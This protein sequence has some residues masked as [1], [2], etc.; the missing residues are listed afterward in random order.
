LWYSQ[1]IHVMDTFS[2]FKMTKI[3][4]VPIDKEFIETILSSKEDETLKT[5]MEKAQEHF[6]ALAA[7][8][9]KTLIESEVFEYSLAS[10]KSGSTLEWVNFFKRHHPL[11]MLLSISILSSCTLMCLINDARRLIVFSQFSHR[12]ALIWH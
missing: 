3:T 11:D 4:R 5:T 8:L 12:V 7:S 2:T 6:S 9:N 10:N 1:Y